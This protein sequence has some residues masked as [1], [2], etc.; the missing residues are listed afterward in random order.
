MKNSIL[1]V[2]AITALVACKKNE[3][4]V[5]D[6]TTDSLNMVVPVDTA[7]MG[8]DSTT[9]SGTMPASMNAQDQMFAESAAKGGMLEVA[10]GELAAMNGTDAKIK[11]HGK[12]IVADHTKAND[13]LK[14]WASSV[15]FTLPTMMDADQQK[16]HDDLK[17]KTGADFDKAY[18]EMMVQDHK[19]DIAAFKKEAA[20]GMDEGLKA[21]A[22]KT[23]PTLEQHLTKTEAA[24]KAMK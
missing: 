15:G 18:A 4:T 3:T 10:M 7:M 5:I 13:A 21:F 14:T 24:V 16:M 1:T 23:L 20:E 6:N 8:T 9:M 2:L 19:D 17:M 22:S 11:E 12:M